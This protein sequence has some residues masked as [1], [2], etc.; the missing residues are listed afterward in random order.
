M[1]RYLEKF[2]EDKDGLV[3]AILARQIL[4]FG[5]DRDDEFLDDPYFPYP[6]E[7]YG[8][9]PAVITALF[10]AYARVIPLGDGPRPTQVAVAESIRVIIGWDAELPTEDVAAWIRELTEAALRFTTT[11]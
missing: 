8:V 9:A 3:D 10:D 4:F 5:R 1:P 11:Q 7:R 6:E 2:E